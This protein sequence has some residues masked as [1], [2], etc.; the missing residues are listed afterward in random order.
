MTTETEKAAHSSYVL[1]AVTVSRDLG[2][3]LSVAD[4]LLDLLAASPLV[5]EVTVLNTIPAPAP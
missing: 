3:A 4:R 1:L 2:G 5:D